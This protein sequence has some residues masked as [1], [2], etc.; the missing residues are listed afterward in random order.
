MTSRVLIADTFGNW[1]VTVTA[2]A[3]AQTEGTD[4]VHVTDDDV[5]ALTVIVDAAAPGPP[6]HTA[7]LAGSAKATRCASIA[8]LAAT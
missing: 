3:A 7:R 6:F 5:A 2:S 8:A 1:P 4:T